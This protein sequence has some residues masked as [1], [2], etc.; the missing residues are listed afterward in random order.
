[1]CWNVLDTVGVW[2]LIVQAGRS[3]FMFKCSNWQTLK[4]VDGLILAEASFGK[5]VS[6]P[7][8]SGLPIQAACASI[9]CK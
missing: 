3:A 8:Y 5:P 6:W 7:A 4:G 9:E 2:Q 1:M